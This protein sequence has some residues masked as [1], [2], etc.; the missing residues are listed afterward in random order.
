M[1]TK[2]TCNLYSKTYLVPDVNY[3]AL[4]REQQLEK[5]QLY[6]DLLNG[7]D[8]SV[9]LQ[10]RLEVAGKNNRYCRAPAVFSA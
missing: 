8:S 1:Q 7:F 3:S 5:M 4:T 9:S 10:I 6:I 2:E